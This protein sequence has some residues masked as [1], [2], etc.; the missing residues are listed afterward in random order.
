MPVFYFEC[1]VCHMPDRMILSPEEG[2]GDVPCRAP[3]C[4]GKLK[5]TRKAPTTRITETLDNGLMA[6]S[7][8]RL[9]DAEKIHHDRA[10][11]ETGVI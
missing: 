8:E 3:D 11:G 4:S 1:P 7:L 6:R 10:H 2:K 5:R 9:A